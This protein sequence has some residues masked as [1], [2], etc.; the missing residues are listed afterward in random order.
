M[1]EP[2][3]A[4]EG[5]SPRPRGAARLN[6]IPAQGVTTTLQQQPQ[7]DTKKAADQPVVNLFDTTGQQQDNNTENQ[8]VAQEGVTIDERGAHFDTNSQFEIPNAGNMNGEAGTFS[9]C[10]QPQWQGGDASNASFV[11]LRNQALYENRLQLF[12]NGRFLRLIVTPNTGVE[13]G[14]SKVIDDWQPNQMHS[15]VATYGK[16]PVTGDNIA[17]LYVDGHLAGPPGTYDGSFDV[18][19]GTPLLVGS[20]YKG[21]APGAGGTM[22]N[23][24]GFNQV[25]PADT[26]A[27]LAAN[28]TQ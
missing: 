4:G 8:A 13:S 3:A 15:V 25:L 16:D 1:V 22:S 23:F 28:C 24:Q 10:I 27:G 26:I 9:F 17:A 7:D 5:S 11:Q 20:D 12:K 18:S 6:D 14:A 2:S 21:D 19:P